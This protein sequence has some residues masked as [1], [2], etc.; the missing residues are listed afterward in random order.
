MSAPA[1]TCRAEPMAMHGLTWRD[2]IDALG[3]PEAAIAGGR[4]AQFEGRELS[5]RNKRFHFPLIGDQSAPLGTSVAGNMWS[6][7][8]AMID[9]RARHGLVRD[10]RLAWVTAS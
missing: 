10:Q 6:M 1:L 3:P 2:A 5:I 8:S 4:H 7:K 9:I